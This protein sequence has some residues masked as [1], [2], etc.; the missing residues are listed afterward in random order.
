[1]IIETIISSLDN[2]GKLNIAPFGIKK[3]SNHIY[4]S[5]YRPSITLNNLISNKCAVVNYIDDALVFVNCIV[6]KK[7]FIKKKCKKIECFYISNALSYDEVKVVKYYD[8]EKRP[9]FKCKILYSENC[10]PFGGMNRSKAA[11][12]EAC[13]L[14]TRTKLLKKEKIIKE[15]KYLS[16]SVKKTSG[17]RESIAWEKITEYIN[18]SLKNKN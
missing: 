18:R 14:A 2:K 9:T 3:T 5:P 16:I 8:D 6:G 10:K 7:R 12:I 15:L 13:I 11:I 4:L 1:M 17:K